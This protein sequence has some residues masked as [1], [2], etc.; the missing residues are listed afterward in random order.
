MVTRVRQA[1]LW[2]AGALCLTLASASRE[3]SGASKAVSLAGDAEMLKVLR[4][5][6]RSN[7][8]GFP[9]GRMAVRSESASPIV[10]PAYAGREATA[11]VHVDGGFEWRGGL[12]RFDGKIARRSPPENVGQPAYESLGAWTLVGTEDRVIV[13]NKADDKVFIRELKRIGAERRIDFHPR[14]W[15]SD[16]Y[17]WLSLLGGENGGQFPE[18]THA[19]DVASAE[20]NVR[21]VLHNSSESHDWDFSLEASLKRDANIVRYDSGIAS[22]VRWS[23]ELSWI[24]SGDGRSVLE[25][26]TD[27][28]AHK[29][30]D[31]VAVTSQHFEDW[32]L[33][34]VPAMRRFRLEGMDLRE[35][36]RVYNEIDGRSCTWS[37]KSLAETGKD[38]G[39][40]KILGERLRQTGFGK[41]DQSR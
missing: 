12:W 18:V 32:N 5:R 23:G 2:V 24:S 22:S 10:G 21:V 27:R 6:Q 41:G 17:S 7:L 29:D 11:T 25:S 31:V 9:H 3:E 28:E 33:E 30:L 39:R 15:V 20:G 1:A 13:F 14:K 8:T 36:T 16:P 4:E 35:T 19:V 40:T 34:H 38:E 26:R 37:R